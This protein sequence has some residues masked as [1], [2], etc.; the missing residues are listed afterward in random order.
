MRFVPLGD[1]YIS[2]WQTRVRDFDAF[3]AATGYDAVGGMSSAITRNGFKLNQMSWKAPG[4]SQTPD[5]PVVG[6]SWEDASQ[7][8]AWLTR[9]E[10]SEGTLRSFQRYRLPTDREWSE[11]IGLEHEQGATPTERSAKVKG[12]YPWGLAFPPP[13]DSLNYAGSESRAG[14]PDTWAV[15]PDY[16]DAYPRTAPVTVFSPNARGLCS[17]GGNVWEW[18]LDKFETGLNWRTL[19]GGSWATSRQEEML[20]SYRRGYGSLFRSDE[21]GFRCVIA[22]NGGDE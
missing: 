6:V 19:R 5:H 16:H 21:I 17:M 10:R 22:S 11:A 15:I 18:C 1:I 3:V 13:V 4:F 2:V 8:C 20:S 12:V 9:K 14:A 7:F